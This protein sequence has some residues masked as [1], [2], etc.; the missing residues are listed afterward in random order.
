M[1]PA[2]RVIGHKEYGNQ[3]HPGRKSD[4]VYEMSW[5]RARVAAFTPAAPAPE[6]EETTVPYIIRSVGKPEAILVEGTF[7]G[8]SG[9]DELKNWRAVGARDVWVTAATWDAYARG[10]VSGMPQR[11]SVAQKRTVELLEQ[12]L[13]QLKAPAHPEGG[14]PV[15]AAQIVDELGQRLAPV[16]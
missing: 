9:V 6:P 16:T 11:D 7:L 4:P 14:V 3:G 15:S 13:G 2:T 10:D 1:L 5:R 8:L 12:L